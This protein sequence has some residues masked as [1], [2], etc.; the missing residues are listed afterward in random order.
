M[1]MEDDN[2][3]P[4]TDGEYLIEEQE[5]ILLRQVSPRHLMDEGAPSWEAFRP[6]SKDADLLSTRRMSLISPRHAF[7]DHCASGLGTV[8]S[9][10]VSVQET[11]LV[12]ARAIDDAAKAGS[13]PAHAS[14]DF[15]GIESKRAKKNAAM[16]LAHFATQRGRLH[17]AET[18]R[19]PR[20]AASPAAREGVSGPSS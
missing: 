8:G 15:R 10:G 1:V 11:A 19:P 13:P 9:W 12:G 2:F 20:A 4:L 3:P 7:E 17:P 18:D 5:E 6:M 16:R 14:V